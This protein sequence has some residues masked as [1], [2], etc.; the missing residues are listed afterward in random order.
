MHNANIANVDL[1]PTYA[2]RLSDF[3]AAMRQE[4]MSARDRLDEMI[5]QSEERQK[6]IKDLRSD[7]FHHQQDAE[8]KLEKM[9]R[10]DWPPAD[11]A[12][13][14]DCIAALRRCE[15]T[16]YDLER[17]AKVLHQKALAC[18]E[19]LQADMSRTG[20]LTDQTVS[21][22]TDVLRRL[23]THLDDYIQHTTVK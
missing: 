2:Q 7:V 19:E 17:E 6:K 16:L 3:D 20:N 21:R 18:I 12:E 14:E 5:E 1:L 4:L 15:H 23:T 8:I 13:Q 22:G 9:L 11:I 10:D